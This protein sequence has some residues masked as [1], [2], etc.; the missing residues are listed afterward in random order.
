MYMPH[1]TIK[2]NLN[3]GPNTISASTSGT[4]DEFED[5]EIIN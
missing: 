2:N 3:I 1:Q 4:S 5:I